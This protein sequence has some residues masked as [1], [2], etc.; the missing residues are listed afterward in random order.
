MDTSGNCSGVALVTVATVQKNCIRKSLEV[1]V[2]QEK[3]SE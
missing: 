2:G 1:I 3:K